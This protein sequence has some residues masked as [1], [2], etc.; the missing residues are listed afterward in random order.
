MPKIYGPDHNFED[1]SFRAARFDGEARAEDRSIPI[2]LATEAPVPTFDF[3][4]REIVDEVLRV[5]DVDLPK[6]VPLL[7]S[8][9]RFTVR[10]VLG[11]I[12]DLT[13]TTVNGVRAITGRAYFAA[14]ADSQRA[15][16]NYADGHTT[17]FSVGARR[18][19]V[20]YDGNKRIVVRSRL[21]E[22]SAVVIGADANAKTFD[23][24]ALRAY[25]DP[26]ALKDEMMN[27]EFRDLLI[28]RG[29]PAEHDDAAAL[30]WASEN[31]DRKSTEPP[32]KNDPSP[33][34]KPEEKPP[35]DADAIRREAAEAEVKRI[36][37]I[38]DLCR[39]HGVPDKDRAE[40]VKGG[41]SIDDVSREILNRLAGQKGK[42]GTVPRIDAGDSQLEK[43]GAA[44]VDSLTLRSIGSGFN[45][46]VAL[47]QAKQCGDADAIERC[48][49]MSKLIEAPSQGAKDLRAWSM[50]DIARRFVEESGRDVRTMARHEIA[51]EAFRLG[52]VQRDDSP[53]YNTTG[54]FANVLLNATNKTLLAAYDETP[55]TYQMWARRAPSVADFREVNRIRFGELPDPEV[56][57]E[58]APYPDKTTTDSR[59]RYSV[60]KYGEI[61]SISLEAVINDDLNAISRI[62]AMQ[63]A[64][65]RR[66]INKVVYAILTDNAALSDGVALF[67]SSSHNANLDAAALA[68][69]AL[70]TGYVVMMTQTGLTSGT[71]L[72]IMPKFLIVPPALAETAIK[73]I[74]SSTPPSHGG[75]AAGTSGIANPYGPGGMRPLTL[76][77]E[78]QLSTSQSATLWFLA[79]DSSQVDT[80]EFAFL[81]GEESP[82][83]SREEGFTIDA[84]RYKIRQTFAAKAID[85]RGLY[86]G[87]S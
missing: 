3:T 70:N 83:L 46:S 4:K 61:F 24:L 86:Q 87:N 36:T 42:P 23:A 35:I 56:V 6:Q 62:P 11:S 17:D 48:A 41:K 14:D 58:N 80:V 57:P 78:A 52:M 45:S 64:A 33:A 73:I 74:T 18:L 29:M 19:A 53:G 50:F 65:M 20:K 72:N 25:S 37:G 38:D 21:L 81:Q 71:V 59:E 27:K 68:D 69:T 54:S 12:R 30:K 22:G 39:T 49:A 67:H 40:W 28:S 15:F 1:I 76:V 13:R 8:H 5:D 7:D 31:L 26:Q 66:K 79:A 9:D 47:E 63:G 34:P 10:S 51:R 85:F 84:L 75:S 60:D 82:V 16:Q 2:V 44:A 77:V 32:P 55:T 43:F